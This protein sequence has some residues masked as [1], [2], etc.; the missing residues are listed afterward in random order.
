[1]QPSADRETCGYYPNDSNLFQVP[2]F[3]PQICDFANIGL[4]DN[5]AGEALQTKLRTIL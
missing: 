5:I 4:P 2:R 1:M 3:T